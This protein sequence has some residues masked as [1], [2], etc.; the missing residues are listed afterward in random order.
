MHKFILA[1][2]VMFS[3]F[4]SAGAFSEI[5][6]VTRQ[7]VA[8]HFSQGWEDQT[9]EFDWDHDIWALELE[10]VGADEECLAMVTGLASNPVGRGGGTYRF[11]VCITRGELG[12]EA[13]LYDTD[14]VGDE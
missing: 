13:E 12:F 7:E 8:N 3:S 14:L 9:F 5:D 10:P 1:I 4:A 6:L 11:W 2:L